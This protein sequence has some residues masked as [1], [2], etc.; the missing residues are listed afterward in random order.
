MTDE[1]TSVL[2]GQLKELQKTANTCAWAL[3]AIFMANVAIFV[4]VLKITPFR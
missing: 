3:A 2:M 1:N 4:A